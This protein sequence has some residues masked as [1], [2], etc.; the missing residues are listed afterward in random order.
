MLEANRIVDA[1][2][3]EASAPRTLEACM[4]E[5]KEGIEE[6]EAAVEAVEK[7]LEPG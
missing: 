3:D 4:E 6:C 7:S 5:L 1:L 2:R